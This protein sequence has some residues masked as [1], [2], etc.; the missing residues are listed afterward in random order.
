MHNTRYVVLRCTRVRGRG[1][2]ASRFVFAFGVRV[3]VAEIK[4]VDMEPT[5]FRDPNSEGGERS[6]QVL[7]IVVLSPEKVFRP[8]EIGPLVVLAEMRQKSSTAK[9]QVRQNYSLRMACNVLPQSGNRSVNWAPEYEQEPRSYT[10]DGCVEDAPIHRHTKANRTCTQAGK[11][12]YEAKKEE[13]RATEIG[14]RL[15]RWHATDV[16]AYTREW[17]PEPHIIWMRP[18][19]GQ[20][21]RQGMRMPD[22]VFVAFAR[23]KSTE[24]DIRRREGRVGQGY[25]PEAEGWN[26][27]AYLKDSTDL[28][29]TRTAAF[30]SSPIRPS[31]KLNN[32]LNS[33]EDRSLVARNAL[34]KEYLLKGYR[35]DE[36]R[37]KCCLRN[38][39]IVSGVPTIVGSIQR[40]EG[41]QTRPEYLEFEVGIAPSEELSV[42]TAGVPDDL[43]GSEMNGKAQD[44]VYTLQMAN[45]TPLFSWASFYGICTKFVLFN[46]LKQLVTHMSGHLKNRWR[47]R[48]T[49]NVSPT[50]REFQLFLGIYLRG[51]QDG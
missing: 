1:T 21:T 36:S 7:A 26:E 4:L 25:S 23:A 47:R 13:R 49:G 41:C 45:K 28:S 33:F 20:R 38:D 5:P 31:Y 18:R 27:R 37:K 17:A 16:A 2:I 32:K 3:R 12:S 44:E 34:S 46:N 10:S 8:Q 22:I 50:F 19:L 30:C 24:R 14:Y 11:R 35:D 9:S 40:N 42:S 15:L 39:P 51:G 48:M 6:G 29:N 43:Q